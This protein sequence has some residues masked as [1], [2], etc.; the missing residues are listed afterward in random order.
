MEKVLLQNACF[1]KDGR[2]SEG[3]LLIKDGKIEALGIGIS[4]DCEVVDLDGA[5]LVPGF[6]DVHTHGAAG[7]DV[8]A[9]DVAGLEKIGKFFASQGTT[10]WLASV[11][12]DTEEQT[13]WCLEQIRRSCSARI[14]KA[15]SWHRS[16]RAQC[17]STCSSRGTLASSANTRLR[18]A[19][20][21][22]ISPFPRRLK[23]FLRW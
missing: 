21:C 15:R 14:W 13:T 5:Y 20:R 8:N 10:G 16:T 4:A 12:T 7:V 23:G 1:Y 2:F 18:R 22:G 3:N 11:L 6:L 9:A 17:L 19:V